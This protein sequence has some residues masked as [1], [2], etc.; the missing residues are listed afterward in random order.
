[1]HTQEDPLSFGALEHGRVVAASDRGY[2]LT[3]MTP[4]HFNNHAGFNPSKP[5]HMFP[6]ESW[7]LFGTAEDYRGHEYNSTASVCALQ[8]ISFVSD[9]QY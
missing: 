5:R 8:H 3:S 9:V 4:K 1:M 6:F 2:V 7:N